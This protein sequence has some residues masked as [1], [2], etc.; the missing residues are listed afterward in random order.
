MNQPNT[1]HLRKFVE[2]ASSMGT[3][4]PLMLSQK[5]ATDISWALNNHLLY[6]RE[7]EAEIRD[8]RDKLA[9]IESVTVEMQ[10]DRF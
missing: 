4:Q 2:K 3:G 9:N 8:L 1:H 6:Q 7:L 10:G 5:D